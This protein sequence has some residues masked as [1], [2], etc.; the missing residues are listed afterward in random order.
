MTL[1]TSPFF[2][3]LF[4]PYLLLIA[5]AVFIVGWLG[6]DRIRETYLNRT[7]QRLSDSTLLI[8]ELT[9]DISPANL[10]RVNEQLRSLGSQ[11]Q[12]RITLMSID[13][14]VL[15]DNEAD[16][17]KMESHRFRPEVISAISQ[18]EG[19]SIRRSD[20]IHENMYYF[21]RRVNGDGSARL[22]RVAVH[23]KELDAQLAKL[24]R[25]L[26]ITAI[27]A[28]MI[29]GAL[30]YYFSARNSLPVVELTKF[31]DAVAHGDL[32]R[33]IHGNEAGEIRTMTTALNHMADSIS[34]LITEVT[35]DQNELQAILAT[36]TEGVIATD[37]D[38][39]IVQCN[40][41]ARHLLGL[42]M[43]S[44]QGRALWEIVRHESILKYAGE[45]RTSGQKQ[46]FQIGPIAGRQ[47]EVSVCPLPHPAGAP[48]LTIV[49]HDVTE[50]FQ[51]QELRKEFVANVSHEL[52]TPLTAIKGFTETLSSW[53]IKDPVKGPQ[54]LSTIEK[55]TNQLTNLV[56]D[57]LELSRLESRSDLSQR[58]SVDM[59]K[60]L[61]T[62][63][64]LF[65]PLAERKQQTLKQE[66][67]D[68][69]PAILGV[70]EYLERAIANLLDN[71]IK[72]TPAGGQ[73]VLRASREQNSLHIEVSDNGIGIP[74]ADITRIFERFYRVDRSRSRE[75]GGTGLGLSIVKHVIQVHG[76]TIDVHSVPGDG[77]TFRLKIPIQ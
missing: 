65:Q 22:V 36:M 74:A 77:S 24:Y 51:F 8:G 63:M 34:R 35:K 43:V 60:M 40:A 20:T 50:S 19:Q 32:S 11:I 16:A 21:A 18:G 23:L 28:V 71:A 52:R 46:T 4:V 58:V 68:A 64:E 42:P 49:A 44:P 9:R 61:R 55:H 13:G 1:I 7:E 69:L 41:A 39:K 70:P 25:G 73:I 62:L 29:A 10:P 27:T 54:Y 67:S 48:G 5:G 17:T 14:T 66:L 75:M 72:Y 56:N 3:R 12:C 38:Q 45:V 53:A 6:G 76:G 2:R 59:D 26:T 30:G 15:G 31:A 37:S 57:L 47:L 33:R